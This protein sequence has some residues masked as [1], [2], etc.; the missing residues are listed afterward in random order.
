[1]LD[2]TWYHKPLDFED[3]LAGASLFILGTVSIT[4]SILVSSVMWKQDKVSTLPT[5]KGA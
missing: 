1:M 4:I 3:I 5:N 2:P